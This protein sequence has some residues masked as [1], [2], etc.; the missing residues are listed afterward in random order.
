MCA[1]SAHV[2]VNST[3]PRPR[4]KPAAIKDSVSGFTPAHSNEPG[5]SSRVADGGPARKIPLGGVSSP[6]SPPPE[7]LR[8]QSFPAVPFR[9]VGQHACKKQ[10]N[11]NPDRHPQIG[12]GERK[13]ARTVCGLCA[14][15]RGR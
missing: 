8:S 6:Y 7:R 5:W 13:R 2:T 1:D 10:Q 12:A 4:V 14:G 9:D 11:R 3:M 15:C